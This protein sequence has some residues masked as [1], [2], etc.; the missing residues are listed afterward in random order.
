MTRLVLLAATAYAA[1][2]LASSRA[3]FDASLTRCVN[4]S[5]GI[6]VTLS[7][8]AH[9]NGPTVASSMSMRAQLL[10]DFLTDRMSTPR[11]RRFDGYADNETRISVDVVVPSMALVLVTSSNAS[12]PEP[13]LVDA[14]FLAPEV[15]EA[16]A[17]CILTLLDPP[18][19]I[20]ASAPTPSHA[21]PH[22]GQG[23]SPMQTT[24]SAPWGLDR[25]D[26][27][28]GLDGKYD[29]GDA[30]GRGA[31]VYILDTGTRVTHSEFGPRISRGWSYGGGWPWVPDGVIDD[32]SSGCS[33]HGTHV[34]STAAGATLGVA[35]E[36]TIIPVQV[37]SCEGPAV[38]LEGA[39]Q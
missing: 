2:G 4:G 24:V 15:S 22:A 10:S 28:T 9:S 20:N 16:E 30:R 35:N 14:L 37:L 8:S 5:A 36:A 38:S 25:I 23:P 31:D 33:S 18:M 1:A 3:H 11:R 13:G 26:S 34:A 19:Q 7:P 27:R 17:N 12:E 6:L 39:W 32:A 21:S 29:A